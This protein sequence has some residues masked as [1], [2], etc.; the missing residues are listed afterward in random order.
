MIGCYQLSFLTIN[1]DTIQSVG[2]FNFLNND[3]VT[4]RDF[5]HP[6]DSIKTPISDKEIILEDD[7]R[8]WMSDKSGLNGLNIFPI[9][10]GML[11][12]FT[13]LH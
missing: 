3:L 11:K 7:Q 5:V 4:T 6:D 13:L 10:V 1:L 2:L 8:E 12:Y 9:Q